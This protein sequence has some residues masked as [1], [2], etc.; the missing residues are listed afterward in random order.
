MKNLTLR[1][2]IIITVSVILFIVKEFE[3]YDIAVA[4]ML[5][6]GLILNYKT[7]EEK[8]D[9]ISNY[10]FWVTFTILIYLFK[11][12][13]I[14]DLY[15]TLLYMLLLKIIVL[16]V[17]YM[18]YRKINV[19]SSYLSKFWI[20]V[21]F[22]FLTELILNSTFGLKYECYILSVV[23]SLETLIII[24]RNKEWKKSVV[25]FW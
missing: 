24:I 18:K 15:N 16:C 17:S 11:K 6:V 21:F 12:I 22:L 20:F 8:T 23:S 2:L 25:S 13:D 10:I 5:L 9:V 3:Y 4:L 1:L 14:F 7:N 19:T